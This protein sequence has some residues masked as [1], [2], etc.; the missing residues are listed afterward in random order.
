MSEAPT[1]SALTWDGDR[2][3]LAK[4]LV[5]AQ[6]ATESIK[7][8]ATNPAFKSKYADLAH[9]VEG[10]V[11]ALNGAGVAVMQSP[12]FDGEWVSVTTM[13]LHET[14]ASVSS[15]LNMR[16][17]KSDPQGVGSTITYARRYALLAMAGGAPEDDDGNAASGPRN[18]NRPEPK[19]VEPAAPTLK[20]R[21][22]RLET[23]LKAVK[24]Q[25]DLRKAYDLA[26]GLCADLDAKDPERLVEINA[27]YE[28]R[29]AELQPEVRSAA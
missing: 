14:G 10:V 12:A 15:I 7:K 16:P 28:T 29:F 13:F 2:A 27:L 20:D 22:D 24:S 23:T 3:P 1:L 26:S 18:E 4:A 17:S 11:P 8:A 5:A 6:K 25:A 21:A 9:V 19:R